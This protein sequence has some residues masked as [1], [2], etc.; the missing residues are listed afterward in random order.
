MGY[1]KYKKIKKVAEKFNL[2]AQNTVLFQDIAPCLP[3]AWLADTLKKASI[4]PLTNEKTKSERIISPILL[5]IAEFY[6]SGFTLFSGE[7]LEVNA[8]QDLAGECD[9]FFI[10]YPNKPYLVSPII[11]LVEAKNEDMEAGK[12]QCAAQMYGAYLNNE[13]E[14]RQV[15]FIYGCTTDSIEWQFMRFEN[16]I[17][18]I[19]KKT[20]T[21]LP[22]ILG[23]WHHILN[24]YLN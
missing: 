15:P 10:P 1:S 17:F 22:E 16:G 8:E 23:V 18:Y 7:E 9:F 4:M 3:S 6:A 19:D 5:E 24:L 13:A 12:A 11:T 14:G 2:D 21:H 20:Y